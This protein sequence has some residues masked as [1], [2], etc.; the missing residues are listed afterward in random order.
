M[1]DVNYDGATL[2]RC[3]RPRDRVAA[4]T[5]NRVH[6]I[7]V[8]RGPYWHHGVE[9]AD[10]SVVQF[11]GEP[12]RKS[13]ASV[14]RTSL[15]Q[16]LEGGERVVVPHVFRF[17][18]EIATQRALSRLGEAGYNVLENN[19]EHLAT[20]VMTGRAESYQADMARR[21]IPQATRLIDLAAQLGVAI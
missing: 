19:C 4:S 8:N 3:T 13:D 7:A 6:H 12:K 9:L 10:G 15:A 20:W 17:N 14:R 18:D 16:F 21:D 1:S 11:T 5:Y 2:R